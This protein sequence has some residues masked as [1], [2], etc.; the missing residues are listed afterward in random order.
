M[1]QYVSVMLLNLVIAESR[2]STDI[3]THLEYRSMLNN[4]T[5]LFNRLPS[6]KNK[7]YWEERSKSVNNHYI[8][9]HFL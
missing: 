4:T 2:V 5:I 1:F 7:T 8:C 9:R 3:I 6:Y